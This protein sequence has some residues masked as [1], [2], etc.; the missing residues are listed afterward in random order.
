[1]LDLTMWHC[2]FWTKSS[3]WFRVFKTM[4]YTKH[5][6]TCRQFTILWGIKCGSWTQSGWWIW[7]QPLTCWATMFSRFTFFQSFHHLSLEPF[8]LC[9]WWYHGWFAFVLD[10]TYLIT[11]IILKL[12]TLLSSFLSLDPLFLASCKLSYLV[13]C[14]C[15]HSRTPHYCHCKHCCK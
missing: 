6:R 7:P 15:I 10:N 14:Y 1:M 3:G 11:K 8:G 13:C 12:W 5:V 4:Q 2:L 9:I